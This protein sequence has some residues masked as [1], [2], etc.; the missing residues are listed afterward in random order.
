ML[1]CIQSISETTS[2]VYEIIIVDNAS[3]DNSRQ[4][5]QNKFPDVKWIQMSYNSGFSRANNEGIKASSGEYLLLL[6]SD[7]IILENAIDKVVDFISNEPEV[8]AASVQ[9]LYADMSA[10]N[11]GNY[12]VK[13]GLNN[14]LTLPIINTVVKQLANLLNVKKPHVQSS[15]IVNYVDWISGAFM[16]VRKSV[17]EKAGL[18]DEDFFL[19]AEEIEWCSRLKKAGKIAVYTDAKAIHLEGG[20]TKKTEKDIS[21]N[22]YEYWKPKG[23]QLMLSGL[24]RIRKQYSVF[25]MF[26]MYSFYVIEIPVLFA[27]SIFSKKI[28]FANAV[29]YSRNVIAMLKYI[30][31]IINN[32]PYFYKIM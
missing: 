30:P 6:N 2:S 27:G 24:L 32:K 5:I 15:D 16:L 19:F 26:L 13:G 8:A 3:D 14:L 17:I 29:N 4:I 25:W 1:D 7:T 12:F 10:Q 31:K 20:T 23:A 21:A 28:M 11:A 9:L 22:Y 18:M